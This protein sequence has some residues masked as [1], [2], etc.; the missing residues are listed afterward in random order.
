[1]EWNT[2]EN[3][4]TEWGNFL[5]WH[6]KYGME[7]LW[8]QLKDGGWDGRKSGNWYCED[9]DD[10]DYPKNWRVTHW[11]PLPEPPKVGVGKTAP[12]QLELDSGV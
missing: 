11:M 4:P 12:V 1:M 6:E 7:T 5:V 3:P 10:D 2:I 9:G 8:F